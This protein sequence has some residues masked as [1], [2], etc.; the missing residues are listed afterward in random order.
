MKRRSVVLF[1]VAAIVTG[2]VLFLGGAGAGRHVQAGGPCNASQFQG[3]YGLSGDGVVTAG[4]G[5]TSEAFEGDLLANGTTPTTGTISGNLTM[6]RNGQISRHSMSGSY[7][8]I[9]CGGRAIFKVVGGPTMHYDFTMEEWT[10]GGGGIAQEL[11]FIETDP[12]SVVTLSLV[13]G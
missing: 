4:G 13:H 5:I 6:S 12:K 1:G 8:M 7:Q 10:T 11:V 3:G 2:A 9:G